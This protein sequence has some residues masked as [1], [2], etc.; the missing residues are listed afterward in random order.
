MT[1]FYIDLTKTLK[2]V[3]SFSIAQ[4]EIQNLCSIE[5]PERLTGLVGFSKIII[6]FSFKFSSL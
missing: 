2:L 5:E 1:L 6:T 4:K 3:I